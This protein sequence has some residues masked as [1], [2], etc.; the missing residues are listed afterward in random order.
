MSICN[1]DSGHSTGSAHVTSIDAVAAFGSALRQF[2]D[3]S[4][5]ALLSIDEQAK[6]ALQWLEHDAPAYWRAQV[7]ERYD[8]VARTRTELESCR[9]RQVA[10]NRPA[11]LEEIS[12]HRAAQRRLREAEEKIE[13]VRRW[14]Q[15][16]REETEE[17]RGRIMKFRL[18]L[19][20]DVPRTLALI[21]RSVATLD[22]YAER[23]PGPAAVGEPGA[24]NSPQLGDGGKADGAAS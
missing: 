2:E 23:A 1:S 13:I 17:Y 3:Q 9:M 7:R 12:A 14:T 11:C 16:V 5:R 15:R 6:G 19:E 21:D 18:A 8:E 10:D 22:S 4:R 20:R 24:L